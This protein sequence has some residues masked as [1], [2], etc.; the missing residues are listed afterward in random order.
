MDCN[1]YSKQFEFLCKHEDFT[2]YFIEIYI[3]FKSHYRIP[4][5]GSATKISTRKL[6]NVLSPMGYRDSFWSKIYEINTDVNLLY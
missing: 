3:F 6:F 5:S 4:E 1:T 2:V